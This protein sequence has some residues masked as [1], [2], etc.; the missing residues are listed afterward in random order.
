MMDGISMQQIHGESLE[1]RDLPGRSLIHS[2]QSC[3]I[4]WKWIVRLACNLATGLTGA[5]FQMLGISPNEP[6]IVWRSSGLRSWLWRLQH[7]WLQSCLL[8]HQ[9]RLVLLL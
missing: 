6:S 7:V 9:R 5:Q 1:A 8:K 4:R 2:S 3:C